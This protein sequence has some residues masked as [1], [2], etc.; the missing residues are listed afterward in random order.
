MIINYIFL[1]RSNRFLKQDLQQQFLYLT[2]SIL[3]FMSFSSSAEGVDYLFENTA[4][5]A[6]HNRKKSAVVFPRSSSQIYNEDAHDSYVDNTVMGILYMPFSSED[7]SIDKEALNY[8]SIEPCKESEVKLDEVYHHT[9]GSE[10]LDVLVYDPRFR[11]ELR[12]AQRYSGVS[13]PWDPLY[14]ASLGSETIDA[15]MQDLA[16]V[17]NPDCL[18]ARFR[19]VYIGS[20]RYQEIR[21]GKKA[22][23][24]ITNK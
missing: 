4:P 21:Y 12:N 10:A 1:L 16:R 9:P 19:F 24:K 3:I 15:R 11:S 7:E 5:I 18:P 17:L 20:K 14:G 2:F 6:S 22:W 8:I 13:V 23:E